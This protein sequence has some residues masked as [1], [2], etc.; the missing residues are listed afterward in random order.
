MYKVYYNNVS[1]IG[2]IAETKV[3][4]IIEASTGEGPDLSISLTSASNIVRDGQIVRIR[5][6]I[7]NNGELPAENAKL[8]ITAPAGTVHTEIKERTRSYSD[9]TEAEKVIDLGTIKSGETVVKE[10]ELRLKIAEYEH[11]QETQSSE[12]LEIQES[13]WEDKQLENIVR[14]TADNITNE[15]KSE[16]YVLTVKEADLQI[17]NIPEIHESTILRKGDKL[18]YK[19]NVENVSETKDL[20]NVKLNIEFPTGIKVDNIS[21]IKAGSSE[22]YEENITINGNTATINIGK[23]ESVRK[24]IKE[25]ITEHDHEETETDSPILD[26]SNLCMSAEVYIDCT[27]EDFY[28]EYDLIMNATADN[29]EAHYSNVQKIK[30]GEM[31]LTL[32]QA[33]PNQ[34]YVKENTQFT[35]HFTVKNVGEEESI[36][37]KIE[38][39][40]PEGLSLVKAEYEQNGEKE[41]TTYVNSDGI[42]TLEIYKL[43]VGETV[44]IAVTFKAN[45]LPDENDKEITTFA[46]LS[47][48]GFDKIESNKEKII[49]EYDP[50]EHKYSSPSSPNNPSTPDKP[51]Y[52]IEGTA[53]LDADK[54][55]K[56]DEGEEILANIPVVL[57]YKKDNS[58]V[59]NSK[60]NQEQRTQTGNDG[61][62]KFDNVLAGEYL[63]LFLY[64][65]TNYSLTTYQADGIAETLN[66][67]AIDINLTFDGERRVAGITDIITVKNSN[68]RDIDIGL[69]VSQKF[70]LKLDKY[71][72]KITRTTPTSGTNTFNYTKENGKVT[73]IEVLPSNVGQSN[74]VIEYKIVVTNVS[75]VSGYAKKIVDYLPEHV[76]FNTELNTDWYLSE[77]GNIYNSSLENEKINPG[78]SKELTLVLTARFT[79]ENLDNLNN[80]AEIYESFNEEGLRDINSDND[81]SNAD[82]IL[83]LVTGKTVEYVALAFGVIVLLGFGIFEINRRVLAKK[84]D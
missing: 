46:T 50:E 24:Y 33:E 23:L 4:P 72:S 35:N 73:K 27:V 26:L 37:N 36:V 30:A 39:Q 1:N 83:S 71:V 17:I 44:D 69:Y 13:E 59:K 82:V 77:N 8:H 19:V 10:Y 45:L 41:T 70:D 9:S 65:V 29:A 34:T 22:K 32:V 7:K 55:G 76:N 40:V 68:I 66:S 74:V 67:D 81:K 43:A 79:E 58:V 18:E 62:Y 63:V 56:R 16:P 21:Y 5:A 11:E 2:T 84:K 54:N 64:D 57:V 14:I 25:N 3:S 20:E 31:K 60:T 78:E 80:N 53:W 52:R 28:G 42:S 6:T 48:S 75:P 15:M 49:V 61:T 51:A 12:D 38:I 47:A